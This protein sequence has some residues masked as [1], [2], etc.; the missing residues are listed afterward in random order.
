MRS[1]TTPAFWRHYRRLPPEI[2]HQVRLAYRQWIVRPD[3]PGL[4]F[5]QVNA[6]DKIYSVRI[7]DNY[8]VLGSRVDDTITWYF[9]GTHDDYLREIA[10]R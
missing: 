8:R 1:K 2:R 9:V 10:K 5:K 3:L 4:R 6:Q 7:T